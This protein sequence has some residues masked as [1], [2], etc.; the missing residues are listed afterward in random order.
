MSKK[1]RIAVVG[2]GMGGLLAATMLQRAGHACTV[3]EQAPRLNKVGAGINIAPNSTRIFRE[4]GLERQM[5]AAGIRPRL[6][7]S[8]AW[9]TG[10]LLFTVPVPEMQERY[11]APFQAFHRGAL[12]EVLYRTL[13]AGT[14]QFGRR[15]AQMTQQPDEVHLDFEDG[16]SAMADIVIGADGVHSRVREILFGVAPADY[17]GLVAYRALIRNSHLRPADNTKWWAP[18][19]YVLVYYTTEARDEI[20]LVTGSPQPWTHGDYQPRPASVDDLLATFGDFHEE[21]QE[22]LKAATEI[23]CWP[24]LERDP[25]S[26][27]SSGR[28]VLLGDACHPTTPHMGQGAGMA[29]ED[30]VVLARCIDEFPDPGVAFQRYESA[31]YARTAR[32]QRDSHA[33]EWTKKDMDADWVYGYDAM[34]VALE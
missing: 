28:A 24:M 33:N 12:Q 8:R 26:P 31:R 6:K 17:H 30:A 32:I 3:Y 25:F 7:F 20:N 1:Y 23:T 18:D 15:L 21:V 27:W 11:G 9:N 2:A 14:V 16:A 10:E 22:V 4:L 29:F 19:R 34:T 13:P 5:Q